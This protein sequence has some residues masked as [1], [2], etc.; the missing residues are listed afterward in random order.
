MCRRDESVEGFPCGAFSCK[1][2]GALTIKMRKGSFPG[3]P[4]GPRA[5]WP[6]RR[7]VCISL[8]RLDQHRRPQGARRE[9]ELTM[10]LREHRGAW[11]ARLGRG[12]G[13]RGS[14]VGGRPGAETE[15]VSGKEKPPTAR[16]R[17]QRGRRRV[18]SEE[19]R[20]RR[21]A[22][23]PGATGTSG[24]PLPLDPTEAFQV[25]ERQSAHQA[26]LPGHSAGGTET[27]DPRRG[28][29]A[30]DTPRGSAG[31]RYRRTGP[32]PWGPQAK[33]RR[34][35]DGA[36]AAGRGAQHGHEDPTAGQGTPHPTRPAPN[37]GSRLGVASPR[38]TNRDPLPLR[39]RRFR[40][41]GPAPR[42]HWLGPEGA[43]PDG[44]ARAPRAAEAGRAAQTAG[45][46]EE[47]PAVPRT[48]ARPPPL[49]RKRP[50]QQPPDGTAA[51]DGLAASPRVP[52]ALP[53]RGGGG[54][55]DAAGSPAGAAREAR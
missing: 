52:E 13:A 28:E 16:A 32:L 6:S 50:G 42:P 8:A 39:G 48:R 2:L 37:S 17:G 7:R 5:P 10:R 26:G 49:L 14:Q 19:L 31:P 29:S 22:Q 47:A 4:E 33:A 1:P 25:P 43:G 46:T 18:A 54:L 53:P 12:P 38:D 44:G 36:P 30:E 24:A 27:P 41:L 35:P 45:P 23:S 15:Q 9:P 34:S 55:V 40:G 11:G 20:R 3:A 21:L 51:T